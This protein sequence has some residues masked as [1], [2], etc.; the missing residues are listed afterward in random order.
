MSE[1]KQIEVNLTKLY[2][3]KVMEVGAYR[4]GAL[5]KSIE[6]K[7]RL[8]KN[9]PEMDVLGVE[10]LPFIDEGTRY[11]DARHITDKWQSDPKWE[12]YMEELVEIWAE[13]F[14]DEKLNDN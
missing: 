7:V 2:Q 9:G 4:T 5:H 8:E 6:V 12:Q 13:D 3:E 10:Y 1:I 14:L 11:I